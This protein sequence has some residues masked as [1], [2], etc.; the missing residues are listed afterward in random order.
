MDG[1][2]T[3][4]EQPQAGR[5]DIAE[6][7]LRYRRLIEAVTDYIFTVRVENGRPAETSHGPNCVAVTGYTPEE[8]AA[9]RLLWIAMVPEEDRA[10]VEE[11]AARILS[12]KDAPPIE[13]RVRRK[14]GAVR[15]VMN[16]CVPHRDSQGKLV[17]YDGLVRDITERK[18]AELALRQLNETLEERV[19]QRTE[20]LEAANRTL[21]Q[22]QF[23]IDHSQDAIFWI[24]PEGRV[25]FINDAACRLTGYVRDELLNLHVPDFDPDMS[26]TEWI[27]FWKR[28][29]S[30][31][32]LLIERRCLTKD[33]EVTPVEVSC[34]YFQF[35]NEE[36]M[37]ALVRD[38]TAR[39]E[40][41][42]A[43]VESEERFRSFMDNSPTIAW[44]K[45]SQG[46]YVYLSRTYE[47][48][49]GVELA[50]WCGKTDFDIWP[51]EIADNFRRNDQQVLATGEVLEVVEET[52]NP[53]GTHCA[54]WAFKFPFQDASGIRYVGGIGVDITDRKRAEERV[55]ASEQRLRAILNTAADAVITID[56]HG[57][58]EAVN[59][60]T[61]KMFGY[62]ER[63]LVGKNVSV[64]MPTPYSAEHDGYISQYLATGEAKIIGI[65]REVVACRRDGSTFPI[66]LAVSEVKELG[67]FTGVI[68]DLTDRKALQRQVLDIAAQEQTRIGQDLHD[69]V[70]QELTGLNYM[71]QNLLAALPD[72]TQAT[73]QLAQKISAGL[74]DTQHRLREVVQGLMPV[75]VDSE[76]LRASL[77]DLTGR[78]NAAQKMSCHFVCS[79]DVHIPD[80]STAMHLYRIA[81]EAVN[82]ALK[83]SRG[84]RIDLSLRA[85]GGRVILEVLDN[86]VGIA[87]MPREAEGLGLGIMHYRAS[88]IAAR[89]H[90]DQRAEVGTVLQCELTAAR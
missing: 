45:D 13:H 88:L 72:K 85:D 73:G 12:G 55:L 79:D 35:A 29:K 17:S 75:M 68:R 80:N 78:V 30:D 16:T 26:P 8:F 64:L 7:E 82:N 54:W 36:F 11:Q 6:S 31:R 63:E 15:W 9:N 42:R 22:T 90:I 44:M 10:A 38:V 61:E 23:T 4:A 81:Q 34:G 52:P 76:G 48:R 58:I 28:A 53:D 18:Q 1:E 51:Q 47:Q 67:L 20:E 65:G 66:D 32:S 2:T 74:K 83:H 69:G 84:D 41:E 57:I 14:D 62:A 39:K 89:L 59:P 27:G 5:Q 3:L 21:R 43:L 37:C 86:G 77:E 71:T 60:A 33:G 19:A 87:A 40:A 49:F 70:G 50:D 56:R 46:H 24:R 25:F